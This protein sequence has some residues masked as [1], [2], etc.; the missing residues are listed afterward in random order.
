MNT[1][2]F[3]SILAINVCIASIAFI[4][5]LMNNV[6]GI[7]SADCMIILI[8]TTLATAIVVTYSLVKLKKK[9]NG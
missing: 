6:F 8:P 5:Y 3:Y 9:M 1:F 2:T 7:A 4:Y